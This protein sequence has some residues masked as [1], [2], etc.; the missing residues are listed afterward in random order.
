LKISSLHRPRALAEM[1]GF[2][3]VAAMEFLLS[4]GPYEDYWGMAFVHA[5]D[6][7]SAFANAEAAV[8]CFTGLVGSGKPCAIPLPMK[9]LSKRRNR[10]LLVRVQ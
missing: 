8:E 1:S 9:M 10:N 3:D 7:T 2:G 6:A 4:V 5:V